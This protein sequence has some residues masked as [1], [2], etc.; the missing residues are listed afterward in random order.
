LWYAVNS[1]VGSESFNQN[2][3][4][5]HLPGRIPTFYNRFDGLLHDANLLLRIAGVNSSSRESQTGKYGAPSLPKRLP[6]PVSIFFGAILV[7]G[8]AYFC[9]CAFDVA[10]T[11]RSRALTFLS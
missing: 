11:G 2:E 9:F 5:N 1:I 3:R 10:E 7:T 8:G 4:L 6:V